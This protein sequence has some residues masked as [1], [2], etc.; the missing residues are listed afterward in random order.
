MVAESPAVRHLSRRERERR[1][2]FN[3]AIVLLVAVIVLA[4]VLMWV[5]RR[6]GSEATASEWKPRRAEIGYGAKTVCSSAARA[7]G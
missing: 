3:L 6:G 7:M 1:K 2:Q 4:L 5:V